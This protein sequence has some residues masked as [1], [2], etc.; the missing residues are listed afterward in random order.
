MVWF[1]FTL[2]RNGISNEIPHIQHPKILNQ[3]GEQRPQNKIRPDHWV[4]FL[5]VTG[6][7]NADTVAELQ[8]TIAPPTKY[9]GP[10]LRLPLPNSNHFTGWKIPEQVKDRTM[11]LC[12]ALES[13][14]LVRKE[15][16]GDRAELASDDEL[17]TMLPASQ[18]AMWWERDEFRYIIDDENLLWP[19][20]V[21]HHKLQLSRGRYP[22][23][24]ADSNVTETVFK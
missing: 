23:W 19:D 16:Y 18:L 4:P 2:K 10:K 7:K 6:F 12:R 20:F 14:A 24:P 8:A 11:A 21:V 9:F 15:I 22:V 3:I 1:P 17:R 5:A 13:S